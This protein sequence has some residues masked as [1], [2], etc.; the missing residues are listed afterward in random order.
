M[1]ASSVPAP[2]G[3]SNAN[4]REDIAESQELLNSLT[5]EALPQVTA[6]IPNFTE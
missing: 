6:L 3:G 4:R 2:F 1:L 5:S